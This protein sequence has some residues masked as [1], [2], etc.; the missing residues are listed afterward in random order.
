MTCLLEF[1]LFF[2][3]TSFDYIFVF[4]SAYAF[5]GLLIFLPSNSAL[6]CVPRF[7]ENC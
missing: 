4:I 3:Q 6:F 7:A 2:G 1:I 5:V